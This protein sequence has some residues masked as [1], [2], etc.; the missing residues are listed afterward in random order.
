MDYLIVVM[1]VVYVVKQFVSHVV[2]LVPLKKNE[3]GTMLWYY[4]NN[5]KDVFYLVVFQH[6]SHA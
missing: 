6:A 4:I 3:C 2:Q 5:I 1:T